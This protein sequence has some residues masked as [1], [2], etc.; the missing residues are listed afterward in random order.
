MNWDIENEMQSGI[1]FLGM[2]VNSGS[3]IEAT[4]LCIEELK[5]VICL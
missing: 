5:C 3:D 4:T 2:L 1:S